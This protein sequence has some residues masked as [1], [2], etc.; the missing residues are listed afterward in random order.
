M[1][2]A[3]ALSEH[4]VPALATGEVIGQVIDAIGEAPDVA[5]IFVTAPFVG[6]VEDM[7]ATVRALLKPGILIGA[8]AVSVLG[9]PLEA[10]EGPAVS[11]WAGRLPGQPVQA[12]RLDEATDPLPAGGPP[13]ASG[14]LVL[15]ADPFSFDVARLLQ[16]LAEASPDLAVV[17]GMASAARGPGGNRL[18]LDDRVQPT[19][20]VGFLLDGGQPVSTVVSQ[21]CRP[22]GRPFTVTRAE[23]NVLYELGGR[24]AY[25]RLQQLVESA[26]PPE[27]D[28]LTKGVHLGV[29]VDEHRTDFERGDFVI[30]NL[31]G[32]D[33]EVGALAAGDVVPVGTTVQFQVRDASTADEDLAELLTTAPAA[34][35]ALLFTCNGRGRHLFDV[36]H[37]DAAAVA[38][39][40]ERGAVAG[41]FCAGEL[42]PIGGANFVHGFT[43]SI[44]LFSD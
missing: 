2:F 33:R 36:A 26:E 44:A 16:R 3:A 23:R 19:G 31:L 20:A 15:L 18:V 40:V 5:A 24:P 29:V 10:E 12:V 42:G 1:P 25:E 35:G 37:H 8:T 32:A 17:G 41:M 7:A 21:G 4:P 34:A 22:I 39:R 6:A 13:A 11:L 9:G 28:L 14:T 30:R 43:A 38:A 27:R